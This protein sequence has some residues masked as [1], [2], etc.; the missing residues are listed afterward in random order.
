MKIPEL[1]A[2]LLV[3]QAAN[4]VSVETPKG[5]TRIEDPQKPV[6]LKPS[7]VPQ[8][9]ECFLLIHPPADV[10]IT[11]EALLDQAVQ[12]QMAGK[13]IQGDIQKIEVG[14]FKSAILTLQTRQ[15]ATQYVAVHATVWGQ[16]GQTLV[17]SASDFEI[18]KRYSTDVLATLSKATAPKSP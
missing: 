8:G 17:Y 10:K 7:D 16:R 11:V 12:A 4:G 6:L 5:W 1:L 18:F 2:V 15:G 13:V 14:I 9:R 3:A